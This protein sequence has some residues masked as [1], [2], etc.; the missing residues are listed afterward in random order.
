METAA[1]S[2]DFWAWIKKA[3]SWIK[4]TAHKVAKAFGAAQTTSRAFVNELAQESGVERLP[5]LSA[6][7]LKS[8]GFDRNAFAQM[9]VQNMTPADMHQVI[10]L[11]L[12]AED[13][14]L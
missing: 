6:A 1:Q 2:K 11:G 12:A 8:M 5:K 7:E 10:L 13:M 3:G 14:N 9:D 4:D